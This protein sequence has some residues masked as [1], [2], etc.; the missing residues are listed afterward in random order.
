MKSNT[1]V[2]FEKKQTLCI[3]LGVKRLV[4]NGAVQ[5]S[6]T[7]G[8]ASNKLTVLTTTRIFLTSPESTNTHVLYKA[9][10]T[11]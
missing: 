3:V 2:C 1:N 5:Q 7:A 9:N 11:V 6:S 4:T 8:A 10:I